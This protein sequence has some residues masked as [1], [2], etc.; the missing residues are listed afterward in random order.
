M[1]ISSQPKLLSDAA[2]RWLVGTIALVLV[3]VPVLN[4]LVP[5]D[6]ALHLSSYWVSLLGKYLCLALLALALDLVWGYAGILS[7]GHG[8]FFALGGYAMGMYLMRQIGERG[9]YGNPVLPDFMVFLDWQELPWYWYGF[10]DF[11]FAALMVVLVP[12]ALAFAFGWFAFRSRV[13]G[14]Y[15]SIITQAL[16]FAL[17]LAFFRNDMGFGGNNGLTDFKDILGFSLAAEGTKSALFVASGVALIGGYLLCRRV[18]TSRLGRVLVAV[19]EAESRTRFLGYRVEHYKLFVFVLSAMLAGIAGALYVP[20]VGIINPG[21]FAPLVSIEIV[22]WV[23]VGGRGYLYGAIVGAL[24]VN[25]GKTWF[26]GAFP[27]IWLFLLGGLFVVSTLFLPRGVVGLLQ[28]R[29]S[30]HQ[31]SPP[32]PSPQAAAQAEEGAR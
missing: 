19:R 9:V 30:S 23:A 29:R 4:L 32:S 24:L 28:R 11:L 6:S 16:T 12:G 18:V 21:E 5:A 26:T 10:D 15:L 3:V 14:V 13:T 17:M 22:V 25:Y 2:S 20:Q 31:P 7:L 27:E 1:A 8:A